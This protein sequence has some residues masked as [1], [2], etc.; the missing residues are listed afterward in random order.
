[1]D[2]AHRWRCRAVPRAVVRAVSPE[3]VNADFAVA[4]CD[5]WHPGFINVDARMTMDCPQLQVIEAFEP[6][7]CALQPARQ[8]RSVNL[9]GAA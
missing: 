9:Q 2:I 8:R 4:A 7:G 6:P 3:L 5:H 1:M